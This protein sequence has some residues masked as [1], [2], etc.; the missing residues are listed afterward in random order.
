M[1]LPRRHAS[2]AKVGSPARLLGQRRV[3]RF[4]VAVAVGLDALHCAMNSDAQS[5]SGGSTCLFPFHPNPCHAEYGIAMRATRLPDDPPA[6]ATHASGANR[7]LPLRHPPVV[8]VCDSTTRCIV[9]LS[10]P[11]RRCK[12]RVRLSRCMRMRSAFSA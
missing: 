2:A 12:C 6:I 3:A 8:G 9:I 10:L 4:K 1:T 7:D 11:I 5:P